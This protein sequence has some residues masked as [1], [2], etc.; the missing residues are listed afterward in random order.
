MKHIEQCDRDITSDDHNDDI[1]YKEYKANQIK[2]WFEF[3]ETNV[4]H[5]ARIK[6]KPYVLS[7]LHEFNNDSLKWTQIKNGTATIGL[8]GSVKYKRMQFPL[9][10]T[11]D[12]TMHKS[13][14]ATFDR[15]MFDYDKC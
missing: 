5:I 8:N 2:L 13:Q 15:I 3:P 10:P 4:G 7:K 1:E 6:C 14:D 11:A 12:I 9:V